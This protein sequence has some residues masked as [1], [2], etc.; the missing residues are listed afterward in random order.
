MPHTFTSA[1]RMAAN[2]RNAQQSTGPRTPEGKERS[3]ANAVKHGL[4]GAGIALP[5]E[6][7]AVVQARFLA[8]QEE[9]A[10]ST[11]L[12]AALVHQVAL[13]TVRMQRAARYEAATLAKRVRSA[14]ADFDEARSTEA[15]RLIAW[16]ETEPSTYRRQLLAMPEGVDRLVAALLG[17][18]SELAQDLVVWNFVHKQK[19]DAY[20]GRRPCDVPHSRCYRLALAIAG[21]FGEI[22]ASE[23]SHLATV[24]ERQTWAADQIIAEIDAEVDRL[25]AHRA[26]LDLEAVECDRAEAEE[27]ALFDPSKEANL[28][29]KYEAAATRGLFRC[30]REFRAV[31]AE[32]HP[33]APAPRGDDPDDD[34]EF[35]PGD[36]VIIEADPDTEEPPFD[37]DK[38]LP[39]PDFASRLGSFGNQPPR[40]VDPTRLDDEGGRTGA[41]RP[42]AKGAGRARA[43]RS[44][45]RAGV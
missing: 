13:M 14:G 16:I 43:G 32:A 12:G 39:V 31:E 20:F 26:T 38:S 42:A 21:D 25:R 10:P 17:L 7:R 28:A 27:R 40:L 9:L 33:A 45:R 35:D 29:R 37:R 3:R 2:R 19:I 44:T 30:L 6:D 22:D 24:P 4:T 23:Y 18:R 11:V 1:A 34:P 8:I 36:A 41:I 15:D 5:K